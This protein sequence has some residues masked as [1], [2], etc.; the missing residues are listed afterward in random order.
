[1]DGVA[2][3]ETIAQKRGYRLKGGVADFEKASLARCR[4]FSTVCSAAS[5]WK[6]RT[7]GRPMLAAARDA[8]DVFT[9]L[10]PAG[11]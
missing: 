7:A 8:G 1:M 9:A 5:A 2:L 6:H 11:D 3:I 10:D 4:T